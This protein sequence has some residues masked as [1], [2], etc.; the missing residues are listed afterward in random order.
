MSRGGSVEI[1]CVEIGDPEPGSKQAGNKATVITDARTYATANHDKAIRKTRLGNLTL[2]ISRSI[3][4]NE[5]AIRW[6]ILSLTA[7]TACV[8]VHLLRTY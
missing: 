3:R 2:A 1:K 7:R 8:Q 5:T 4:K 6:Q